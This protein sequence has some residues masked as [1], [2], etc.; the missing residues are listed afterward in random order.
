MITGDSIALGPILNCD[1]PAIFKW[2]DDPAIARLNEPYLP[3]DWAGME[4]FWTNAQ[5][6]PSRVFF[7]I[8]PRGQT[9]IAGLVQIMGIQPIHRSAA[10][11][12]LIGDNED[13]GRGMGREAMDLTVAYCWRHLN[14]SR[15]ALNVFADN[16][17]A[18]ALYRRMGFAEEG[19]QRQVL[20]IDGAWVDLVQMALIHPSRA[21]DAGRTLEPAQTV[22]RAA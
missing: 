18:L 12:V 11:G 9:R 6:D 7:A 19:V 22:A 13:R 17:P 14:L 20:F 21:A 2:Y 16:A 4:R 8:R 10:L 3:K 5:Q 1:M 15:L